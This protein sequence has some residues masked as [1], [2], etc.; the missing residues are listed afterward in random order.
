MIVGKGNDEL[1]FKKIAKDLDLGDK[2]IFTGRVSDEDLGSLYSIATIYIGSGTAELQGLAVMEAMAAGLPVLAVNAVALPELVENDF[3]GYLFELD[4]SDLSKKMLKILSNKN[5]TEMGKMSLKKFKLT[6]KI[7]LFQFLRNS[8]WKLSKAQNQ[9]DSINSKHYK[10]MLPNI[11]NQKFYCKN[12]TD[13]RSK[14][15]NTQS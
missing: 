3:N 8:T 10:V 9:S 5:I 15:A 14:E 12:C 6:I 7:K 13:K 11:C 4:E 1:K 2:A